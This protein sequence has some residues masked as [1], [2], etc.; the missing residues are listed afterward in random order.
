MEINKSESFNPRAL[1]TALLAAGILTISAGL[2]LQL[3]LNARG[4]FQSLR[5]R[6]AVFSVGGLSTLM[7][8]KLLLQSKVY[9]TVVDDYALGHFKR[10][11]RIQYDTSAA[12]PKDDFQLSSEPHNAVHPSINLTELTVSLPHMQS[13]PFQESLDLP[14]EGI[15]ARS[16]STYTAEDV[17]EKR[18]RSINGDSYGVARDPKTGA[19]AIAVADGNCGE[20][21]ARAAQA[22]VNGFMHSLFEKPGNYH[23]DQLLMHVGNAVATQDYTVRNRPNMSWPTLTGGMIVPIAENPQKQLLIVGNVGNSPFYILRKGHDDKVKAFRLTRAVEDDDVCNRLGTCLPDAMH[24]NLRAYLLEK[25]DIVLATSDGFDGNVAASG[26]ELKKNKKNEVLTEYLQSITF[27][28]TAI[29]ESLVSRCKERIS[30]SQTNDELK[31]SDGY[32]RDH[33][34]IVAVRVGTKNLSPFFSGWFG[35]E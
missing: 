27:T 3:P 22:V 18:E 5:G 17:R 16:D 23:A 24:L 4:S 33:L 7:G 31:T 13:H 32:K 10:G 15:A 20:T 2:I 14:K 8:I 11:E 29:V 25:G 6:I 30:Q 35:R 12:D 28:P 26:W 21:G 1:G 34:T 19:V 9:Q